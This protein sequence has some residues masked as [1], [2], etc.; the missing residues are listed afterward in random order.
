MTGMDERPD[1]RPLTVIDWPGDGVSAGDEGRLLYT[2]HTG[3]KTRKETETLSFKNMIF[4]HAQVDA[5]ALM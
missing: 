4:P 3:E 1:W 2:Q 5:V